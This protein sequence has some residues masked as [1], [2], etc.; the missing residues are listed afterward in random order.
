MRKI[1]FYLFTTLI[2]SCNSDD[3]N[4]D[5][6]ACDLDTQINIEII[7]GVEQRDF[8][9]SE[10]Q[11]GFDGYLV[12]STIVN[13]NDFSIFG[14]S[15]YVIKINDKI[16]SYYN[17]FSCDQIDGNSTCEYE[18]SIFG[19]AGEPYDPNAELLCF[20]YIE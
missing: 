8:V 4:A 16:V 1:T 6:I 17:T 5:S 13:N 2:F 9:I 20:Y 19:E 12:T 7:E 10:Y 18:R 11:G 14:E 15:V 3:D